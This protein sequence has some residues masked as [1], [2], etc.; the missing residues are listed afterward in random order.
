MK[1]I[2]KSVLAL[3]AGV[4]VLGFSNVVASANSQYSAARSNSVKLVWRKSMGRHALTATQGARYSKH[5]GIRYSNNDVTES[6]TWYTDA[7]E[8]LYRKAKGNSAIYY[9]VQSADGTLQGWIWRGYLKE[10]TKTSTSSN[11]ESTNTNQSS[12]QTPTVNDPHAV[13]AIEGLGHGAKPDPQLMVAA[14]GFLKDML[15]NAQMKSKLASGTFAIGGTYGKRITGGTS[16]DQTLYKNSLIN[17]SIS[18]EIGDGPDKAE[19]DLT[20]YETP[21]SGYNWADS[22]KGSWGYLS[23][24][25]YQAGTNPKTYF[26]SVRIGCATQ[27]VANNLYVE[28]A[29]F[30]TPTKYGTI[31]RI[32]N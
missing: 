23:D 22:L 8:K 20:P 28:F 32:D 21:D 6:V 4:G 17:N 16:A 30:V 26:S 10:A 25:D 1:K 9:H 18:T 24:W 14:K 5:L 3:I 7:H 13:Q 31:H 2:A 11:A 12:Q 15:S 19:S 29:V 27:K